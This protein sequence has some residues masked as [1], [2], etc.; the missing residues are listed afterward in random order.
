MTRGQL[1][2]LALIGAL[3]LGAGLWLGQLLTREAAPPPLEISGILLPEPRAIEDFTLVDQDGRR[4]GPERFKDRWS[5]L[6]FG[7]TYCP[8]VCPTTLADLAEL[9]R[10]LEQQGLSADTTYWL[11][12]VDP[13][14]DTPER[15]GD[16]A[17]YFHPEFRGAT[18]SDDQLGRLARQLGVMYRVPNNPETEDYAVDHSSAV[19]LVDPAGRLHAVFTAHDPDALA[20]DFAEIRHRYRPPAG[21]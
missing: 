11:I 20:A 10:R 15:L 8:D 9:E 17:G 19:I 14:R 18:G 5:F 6:Y 3:A 16:Y 7:Y 13:R 4:F 1:L 21:A 12:S 2:P